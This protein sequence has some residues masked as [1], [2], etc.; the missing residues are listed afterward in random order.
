MASIRSLVGDVLR[1]FLK[2]PFILHFLFGKDRSDEYSVGLPQKLCLLWRMWR[3]E[4]RVET[5]SSLLEHL[6]MASAMLRIPRSVGGDVIECGCYRGGSSVNLSLVCAMVGR[7]L[8]ICDSFEGLP[9]PAEYDKFHF[10][11][12]TGHT[13]WYVKGRFAV[14]LEEVKRN[15]ARYGCLDVCDF[16]VG[17]FQNTLHRLDRNWVLGF[18]DVDLVDSLRPCLRA[19]WPRLQDGCRIYVHEARSLFFVALFFDSAWW[20]GE[21]HED[22]PGLVGAGSGLALEALSGSEL[23]YAQKG[24]SA[25]RGWTGEPP[26]QQIFQRGALPSEVYPHPS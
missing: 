14:G 18:L 19:I 21:V 4:R 9:E 17:Y 20:R 2:L 22:A 1:K 26:G 15:L 7:R 24:S 8:V 3:N 25:V 10:A 11:V 23:G 12:H 5:L 13:D 6:E 16:V